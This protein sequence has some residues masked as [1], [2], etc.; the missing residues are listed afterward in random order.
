MPAAQREEADPGPAGRFGIRPGEGRP[1]AF[2]FAAFFLILAGYFVVRPLRDEVGAADLPNLAWMFTA[3]F[4]VTLAITPL[5]G[6]AVSRLGRARYV[7]LVLHVVAALSLAFHLLL[8]ATGGEPRRWI[9]IGLFVW[10]SVFNLLLVTTFWG[11]V[12][13]LFHRQQGLRLFGLVSA[14]GTT[15]A[16]VGSL[17]AGVLARVEG[18]EP[19]DL[20]LASLVLFEAGAV[21]LIALGR[22]LGVRPGERL[23]A[24]PRVRLGEALAAFAALRRSPYLL[25]IAGNVLLYTMTSTIVYFE[26][27]RIVADA[28]RDEAQRTA[29]FADLE[30]AVQGSTLLIQF[31]FAGRALSGLGLGA[32]LALV[33]LLTVLAFG[34]LALGAPLAV[35]AAVAILRRAAHFALA[36]P[37][38]EVLFTVV[39][40]EDKY[41]AK[42]FIDTFVY[43]TSD[44]LFGWWFVGLRRLGSHVAVIG[45]AILPVCALWVWLCARLGRAHASLAGAPPVSPAPA[46]GTP[47]RPDE[48]P[49]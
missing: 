38:Q 32:C 21:A 3:T 1:V 9:A 2:A 28:I 25:A 12:A 8:G 20:L 35:V 33:P 34:L 19:R 44:A 27:Q 37:A 18:F 31:L 24:A 48:R 7:P 16:L 46:A 15:G 41:K 47:P 10:I 29:L 6:Y 11:W 40:R 43:R 39:S 13:D 26:Q 23:G 45:I 42:S 5:I 49:A 36:K 22:S 17:L 4:V 14:G 30:F